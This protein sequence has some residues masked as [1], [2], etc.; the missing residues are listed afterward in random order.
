MSKHSHFA[1]ATRRPVAVL[2]IV[3]AVCVF[4]YVSY[5]KLAVTLMPNISYPTLT[6]RTE[7]P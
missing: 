4:G 1:V 7:Y 3:L 6:V 5:R 2:M